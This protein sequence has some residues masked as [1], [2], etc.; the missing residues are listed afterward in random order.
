MLGSTR[1]TGG[2]VKEYIR[3]PAG[4]Q[5]LGRPA[6]PGFGVSAPDSSARSGGAEH[7]IPDRFLV[8][9]P[10]LDCDNRKFSEA[11][12]PGHRI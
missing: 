10:V 9:R 6:P 2:F 11:E 12:S 5:L 3:I 4:G 7:P 8:P 1:G